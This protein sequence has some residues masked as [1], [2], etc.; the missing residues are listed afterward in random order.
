[1]LNPLPL[2]SLS[3]I[4]P[5]GT[6]VLPWQ[7]LLDFPEEPKHFG[8]VWMCQSSPKQQSAISTW[9]KSNQDFTTCTSVILQPVTW[10]MAVLLPFLL[11]QLHHSIT[12]H[13]NCSKGQHSS[14]AG[15]TRA[16]PPALS[17]LYPEHV[18]HPSRLT[19]RVKH[20]CPSS[21]VSATTFTSLIYPSESVLDWGGGEKSLC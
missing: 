13:R 2:T 8:F 9:I 10:F 11:L 3:K 18:N 4:P 6:K 7:T 21:L 1:M 15:V 17:L 14:N 12:S 19:T 20:L 5:K 16:T